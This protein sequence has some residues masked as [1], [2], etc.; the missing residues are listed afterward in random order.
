MK[1]I[2]TKLC[3][4]VIK[5]DKGLA[6]NPFWGYCTLALCTPNHMGIKKPDVGDFWIC[7]FSQK[8]YGNKLIYAMRVDEV[9]DFDE[10]Y[11]DKRF[12]KKKPNINGSWQETV[13]DNMYYLDKK[14][15]WQQHKTEYHTDS[16]HKEQDQ[17]YHKVFIS[18]HYYYFGERNSVV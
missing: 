4:Y 5:N 2:L 15:D 11:Y 14:G 7:G 18:D 13:G 1:T 9:L 16:K 12:S 6:P 8:K 3:S 17:K 10:Y